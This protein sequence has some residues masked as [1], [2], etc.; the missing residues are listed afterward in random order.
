MIDC[1]IIGFNDSNFDDYVAMLRAMGTE[2]GT[3]R[4]LN[5]A[6]IEYNNKPYR[7]LDILTHFHDLNKD[8]THK[9]LHNFDYLSPTIM[10][11]GSFLSKR[12]FVFDYVNLFHL[13]KDNLRNKLIKEDI[14]SIVITTT[15]Y[16]SP[17]PIIEVI[18]FIRKYNKTTKIVVGGPYIANQ[19]IVQDKTLIQQLFKYLD[20]DYYVI[21][22]EGELALVNLLTTLKNGESPTAVENIA[23]RGKGNEDYVITPTSTEENSLEENRVDYQ[24]FSTEEIGEFVSLRTAKS[25]PFS[26]N[27]CGFPQRAGKYRYMSVDLIEKEL[28]SINE[29]GHVTTLSF[30]DDTFNV[31][32]A[33]FKEILH[34][35]IRNDYGFK[36]NSFYRS[37]HG[38]EEVIELMGKAGC[39]GVFLGVESG[40]DT[41]LKL[42][43]KSSR[44]EHYLEAIPLLKQAGIITHANLVVGFP[45]ETY[46]SV[47]ETIDFIETIQPDYFRA[48]LW[49]ADSLTPVWKKKDEYGIQGEGFN[50]SHNS[51]DSQ[52]VSD[53]ID[54]EFFL[55]E[56]STWLP[57]NGFE[58]WSTLY[59][60]RK[61][62]TKEQIKSFVKCFNAVVREQLF[63]PAKKSIE[64]YLLESL[65]QSCHFDTEVQPNHAESLNEGAILSQPADIRPATDEE[66][67]M[68]LED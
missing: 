11:L 5:L 23:Y 35:M 54:D 4:D 34:M 29:L 15:F 46:E 62:M 25:C 19:A 28:N 27:F 38:D 1:L 41:I 57:Q 14:L 49:Y 7:A 12:G 68:L 45:G 63:H 50:W 16:V 60:Q 40:S 39:E 13:E 36:W 8:G 18:S 9:L 6:F 65:K 59:L 3:Y 32:K 64:P 56:N 47:S 21:S 20:A 43:N 33:R 53:L 31:P 2:S 51:M 17:H 55:I 66:L 22:S 10:C 52:T 61:G 26:C 44:R 30:L 67:E 58:L 42:M 37:D 24:L 48:Q